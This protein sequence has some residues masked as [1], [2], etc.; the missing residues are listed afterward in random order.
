M[1]LAMQH[2]LI[3]QQAIASMSSDDN[4]PKSLMSRGKGDYKI[5]TGGRSIKHHR[6]SNW[7]GHSYWPANPVGALDPGSSPEQPAAKRQ[8]VKRV[9]TKYVYDYQSPDAK[10]PAVKAPAT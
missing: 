4:K 3:D 6:V 8:K 1:T 9:P 10:T 7:S 2:P 5:V